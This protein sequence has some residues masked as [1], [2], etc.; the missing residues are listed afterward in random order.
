MCSSARR[1]RS[2]TTHDERQVYG[3]GIIINM[4]DD[5]SIECRRRCLQSSKPCIGIIFRVVGRSRARLGTVALVSSR[6]GQCTPLATCGRHD[7]LYDSPH[8]VYCISSVFMLT[9]SLAVLHYFMNLPWNSVHE[10]TWCRPSLYATS[11]W[12]IAGTMKVTPQSPSCKLHRS[13]LPQGLH[14]TACIAQIAQENSQP[15]ALHH[16]RL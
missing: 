3:Y 12:R 2:S 9:R 1:T 14:I 4:H 11:A 5:N 8:T 15:M 7:P 6:T 10:Q 16:A 13:I